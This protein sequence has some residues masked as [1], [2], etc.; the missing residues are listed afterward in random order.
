MNA[1]LSLSALAFIV[2]AAIAVVVTAT[3]G[4]TSKARATPAA[5]A[6]ISVKQTA[7][8][9]MLTDGS[10][11]TLYL[12]APDKR[13]MSTLSSAGRAVWPPFTASRRP[14]AE[15]GA[16][17]GQIGQVSGAPGSAQV[18]YDGHPLYYFVGD[19]QPGQSTGQGLNEFGGR[20]YVLSSAGGAITAATPPAGGGG[21]SGGAPSYGSYGY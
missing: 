15:H 7:L 6:S 17:A 11:R 16:Q 21:A 13:N 18:T 20:W 2:A 5:S 10:G 4:S 12:F 19:R 1:R 8:G 9:S 14:A 3:G